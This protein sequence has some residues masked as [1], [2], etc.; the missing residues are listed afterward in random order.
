MVTFRNIF[1]PSEGPGWMSSRL[2]KS[3]QITYFVQIQTLVHLGSQLSTCTIRLEGRVIQDMGSG[4]IKS[5]RISGPD[6]WFTRF[7]S[8]ILN[9]HDP[10]NSK[11]PSLSASSLT[12]Q[13]RKR[14]AA[15]AVAGS[16]GAG[17]KGRFVSCHGTR[18]RASDGMADGALKRLLGAFGLLGG[19]GEDE[20]GRK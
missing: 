12:S 7:T 15:P 20:M 1:L 6:V 17:A 4:I 13:R 9:A 18:G 19:S 10:K 14:G 8:P 3:Y 11:Q 16:R 2:V 5:I